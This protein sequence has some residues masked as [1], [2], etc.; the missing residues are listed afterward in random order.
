[1]ATGKNKAARMTF[2]HVSSKITVIANVIAPL[3]N[4]LGGLG[5]GAADFTALRAALSRRLSLDSLTTSA[6]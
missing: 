2:L 5:K 1:M 6:P 3:E 4:R